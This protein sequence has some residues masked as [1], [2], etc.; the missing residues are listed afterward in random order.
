MLEIWI[1]LATEGRGDVLFSQL[2]P[3]IFFHVQVSPA[4]L[5]GQSSVS[6]TLTS[7]PAE[8]VL[9]LHYVCTYIILV[10]YSNLHNYLNK[11][12]I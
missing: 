11:Q 12:H 7:L 8:N 4:Q 5:S 10:Y 3:E 2:F 9:V 6:Q 1:P